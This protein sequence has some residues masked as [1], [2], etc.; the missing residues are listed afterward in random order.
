M[1]MRSY[2]YFVCPAGHRGEEKTSEN[3]QPYSDHWESV[4]LTGLR[5]GSGGIEYFCGVCG[6]PMSKTSKPDER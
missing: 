1:T 2:R 5:E 4:S 6:A 3:D